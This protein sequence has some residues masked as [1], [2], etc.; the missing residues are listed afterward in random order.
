LL[1]LRS[2]RNGLQGQVHYVHYAR[3]PELLAQLADELPV[4]DTLGEDAIKVGA[5]WYHDAQLRF[6]LD[7]ERK[8]AFYL[9]VD[10]IFDKKPPLFNDT[11]PVTF[12]GTQT[13]AN[14]YDLYGRMIYA[15][16]DFKF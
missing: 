3:L 13:S 15:G 16:V 1:Y 9:G 5:F 8:F 7:E 4:V 14:T 11:N 6:K 12:P 2:P 10:N